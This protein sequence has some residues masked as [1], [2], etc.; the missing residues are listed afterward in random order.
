MSISDLTDVSCSS[1]SV[2]ENI[3]CTIDGAVVRKSDLISLQK[4]NFL[5]D[6]VLDIGVDHLRGK[7][8]A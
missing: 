2:D 8:I 3:L 1:I 4:H 5:N 7:F 6:T